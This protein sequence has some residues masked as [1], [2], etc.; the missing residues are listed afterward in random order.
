MRRGEWL[1][2]SELAGPVTREQSP[3]VTSSDSRVSQDS[4]LP[5]LIQ[6]SDQRGLPQPVICKQSMRVPARQSNRAS[7]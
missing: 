6:V 4:N 2:G 1:P 3:R 7:R 5:V